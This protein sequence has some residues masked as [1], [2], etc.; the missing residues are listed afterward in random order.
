MYEQIAEQ[1]RTIE[2]AGYGLRAHLA[3]LESAS[4]R[5]GNFEVELKL[6][7]KRLRVAR[8]LVGATGEARVFPCCNTS[9]LVVRK[10]KP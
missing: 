8:V 2:D 7:D 9:R 1:Y 6:D 5:V 10:A 4:A 3:E